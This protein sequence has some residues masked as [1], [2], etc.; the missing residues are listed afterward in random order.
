MPIDELTK[1][2]LIS[3]SPNRINN[4]ESTKFD[5]RIWEYTVHG[6]NDRTLAIAVNENKIQFFVCS[7][8]DFGDFLQKLLVS[9][10]DKKMKRCMRYV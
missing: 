8:T 7:S 1:T 4:M 2:Q 10:L 3:I 9:I 5:L 6:V